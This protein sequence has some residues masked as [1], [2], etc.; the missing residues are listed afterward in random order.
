[1]AAS[2]EDTSNS[3]SMPQTSLVQQ[4]SGENANEKEQ[5]LSGISVPCAQNSDA[6]ELPESLVRKNEVRALEIK[7][8]ICNYGEAIKYFEEI[9]NRVEIQDLKRILEEKITFI[10]KAS[11]I[12]ELVSLLFPDDSECV[13]NIHELAGLEHSLSVEINKMI[14]L[15]LKMSLISA[16][17]KMADAVLHQCI[18]KSLMINSKDEESKEAKIINNRFDNSILEVY[19]QSDLYL[20]Q[21]IQM[22]RFKEL[23]LNDDY[24]LCLESDLNGDR[25][26]AERGKIYRSIEKHTYLVRSSELEEKIFEGKFSSDTN[27]HDL[28]SV[29]SYISRQNHLP[30]NIKEI[31]ISVAHTFYL[32]CDIQFKGINLVIF[33]ADI[34]VTQDI[35]IDLSGKDGINT[36]FRKKALSGTE[37]RVAND[38]TASLKAVSGT[39]GASG[40]PGAWGES[41]GNLYLKGKIQDHP[42]KVKLILNGGRG[43]EGQEGGDGEP[44]A[45]GKPGVAGKEEDKTSMF[46]LRKWAYVNKAILPKE[47]GRGGDCGLGGLGGEGGYA[48]TAYINDKVFVSDDPEKPC[49]GAPGKKSK[50]GEVGAGGRGGNHASDYGRNYYGFLINTYTEEEF[51][52]RLKCEE[53]GSWYGNKSRRVHVIVAP[54][55]LGKAKNG[56]SGRVPKAIKQEKSFSIQRNNFKSVSVENRMFNS[57]SS[58]DE[59]SYDSHYLL[60]DG[61]RERVK[62]IIEQAK[63]EI[64]AQLIFHEQKIVHTVQQFDDPKHN[65]IPK[66][67]VFL[68]DLLLRQNP[69]RILKIEN[70]EKHALIE[71]AAQKYEN[72]ELFFK[73]GLENIY[74]DII[75]D[76]NKNI[77]PE[78]FLKILKYDMALAMLIYNNEQYLKILNVILSEY[79]GLTIPEKLYNF[80]KSLSS[81]KLK[82]LYKFI[83]EAYYLKNSE[84]ED[85]FRKII[86]LIESQITHSIIVELCAILKAYDVKD[87]ELILHNVNQ[88]IV[89]LHKV[90]EKE[91]LPNLNINNYEEIAK[92]KIFIS[93]SVLNFL[94][95]PLPQKD[96]REKIRLIREKIILINRHNSVFFFKICYLLLNKKQNSLEETE[97][98]FGFMDA[99]LKIRPLHS[100]KYKSEAIEDI[101]F[102]N[103]V[104][105]KYQEILKIVL[106][107]VSELELKQDG[108]L[109]FLRII[110]LMISKKLLKK[111]DFFYIYERIKFV[112]NKL[113]H[114][115]DQYSYAKVTKLDMLEEEIIVEVDINKLGEYFLSR[116]E[117]L[118]EGGNKKLIDFMKTPDAHNLLPLLDFI[119]DEITSEY[120]GFYADFLDDLVRLI[121]IRVKSTSLYSNIVEIIEIENKINLCIERCGCKMHFRIIERFIELRRHIQHCL[122]EA[123]QEIYF[124]GFSIIKE[125]Y[126]LPYLDMEMAIDEKESFRIIKSSMEKANIEE[127]ICIE[128]YLERYMED[129]I[130]IDLINELLVDLLKENCGFITTRL[131]KKILFFYEAAILE[132]IIYPNV[133]EGLAIKLNALHE[134]T[135]FL[136]G[137]K[138][139]EAI[140][141]LLRCLENL[142]YEGESQDEIERE[143]SEL[144]FDFSDNILPSMSLPK[145][146]RTFLLKAIIENSY[147]FNILEMECLYRAIYFDIPIEVLKIIETSLEPSSS[148]NNR[149]IILLSKHF[150]GGKIGEA[151]ETLGCLSY[152]LNSYEKNLVDS[153]KDEP[154]FLEIKNTIPIQFSRRSVIEWGYFLES[155]IVDYFYNEFSKKLKGDMQSLQTA[156]VNLYDTYKLRGDF[157]SFISLLKLINQK[158]IFD[159][160][161]SCSNLQVIFE[162]LN[163][164]DLDFEI[165]KKEIYD[166][167]SC[168]WIVNILYQQLLS[169]VLKFFEYSPQA[170]SDLKKYS[171]KLIKEM[172]SK[173]KLN[174]GIMF[175]LNEKLIQENKLIHRESKLPVADLIHILEFIGANPVSDADIRDLKDTPLNQW[176]INLQRGFKEPI[177]IKVEQKPDRKLLLDALIS[178]LGLKIDVFLQ[179]EK[180]SKEEYLVSLKKRIMKV[181]DYEN[182]ICNGFGIAKP[183]KQCDEL[184]FQSFQ[185]KIKQYRE[186]NDIEFIYKHI[187]FIIAL[188]V[189][190]VQISKFVRG[191]KPRESQL[192]ALYLYLDAARHKQG[193]LGEIATGEGKTLIIAMFSIIQ[194]L[195]GYK[196]NIVTSSPVL[197][198]EHAEFTRNLYGLFGLTVDN[199][200][201]TQAVENI[202]QRKIRYARPIVYGDLGSF[203]RD[204][205][206]TDCFKE[207]IL[208]GRNEEN[209]ILVV[210]EVDSLILDKGDNTLY[211]GHDIPDFRHLLPI[212][213]HIWAAAQNPN[214]GEEGWNKRVVEIIKNKI[215]KQEI[216]IVP[217]LKDF[218]DFRLPIWVDSARQACLV[219]EKRQFI[220][221]EKSSSS[222]EKDVV[223]MDNDTGVEQ[224]ALHWSDGLHQFLQLAANKKF[225]DESLKAIF[226]SNLSYFQNFSGRIFG[227]TGTLGSE[228]DKKLFEQLYQVDF[229]QLPRFKP[230]L[231]KKEKGEVLE[232]SDEWLKA[233]Q[234]DVE[235]KIGEERAVLLIINTIE[236]VDNIAEYLEE[237]GLCGIHRYKRSDEPFDI[238]TEDKP[239]ASGDIIIATNLAGRGKDLLISEKL[240][241]KGGLHVILCYMPPNQR[242]DEQA[243]GRAARKGEKG[244]GKFIIQ[245]SESKDIEVLFRNR[246]K[247]VIQKSENFRVTMLQSLVIERKLFEKFTILFDEIRQRLKHHDVLAFLQNI[248]DYF[249][250]QFQSWNSIE[251]F[252]EGYIEI[253]LKSLKDAWSFWLDS[254]REDIQAISRENESALI[255]K[256]DAFSKIMLKEANSENIYRLVKSPHEL[257][258]LGMFFESKRRWCA[259]LDCYNKVIS[260]CPQH[261]EIAQLRRIYAIEKT[262]EFNLEMK[263]VEI[264]KSLNRAFILMQ[265]RMNELVGVR[266][267]HEAINVVRRRAGHV[268]E[269]N[270][271][272]GQISNFIRL[273]GMHC[274]GI[275]NIL[276]TSLASFKSTL[277]SEDETREFQEV[278]FEQHFVRRY[279]LSKKL[280]I[281]EN[282]GTLSVYLDNS[283][284]CERVIFPVYLSLFE[285]KVALCIKEHR[286]NFQS[287]EKECIIEEKVFD[288][289]AQINKIHLWNLLLKHNLLIEKTHKSF[290][291]LGGD[292]FNEDDGLEFSFNDPDVE[293]QVIALLIANEHKFFDDIKFPLKKEEI[294]H[295]KDMLLER[296]LLTEIQS[297]TIRVLY[298]SMRKKLFLPEE[299]KIYH[300]VII[301]VLNIDESQTIEYEIE[302]ELNIS[303][304]DIYL[305]ADKE[306]GMRLIWEFMLSSKIIKPP[307]ID[308]SL[309]SLSEENLKQQL[310]ALEKFSYE[311]FKELM[312]KRLEKY[313]F[314]PMS[315]LLEYYKFCLILELPEQNIQ[316]AE[317]GKIYISKDE[318]NFDCIFLGLDGTPRKIELPPALDR[319]RELTN[320]ELKKEILIIVLKDQGVQLRNKGRP[321]KGKIYFDIET[322]RLGRRIS[323]LFLEPNDIKVKGI[324]EK[325]II[326]DS[327]KDKIEDVK[328]LM[329]GKKSNRLDIDCL[330]NIDA[331]KEKREEVL[332]KILEKTYMNSSEKKKEQIYTLLKDSIGQLRLII[333]IEA[334]LIDIAECL[335]NETY[336]PDVQPFREV[337]LSDI[338]I[339][340]EFISRWNWGAFAVAMFGLVQIAGGLTLDILTLGALSPLATALIAEGVGDIFFAA[341]M[342]LTKQFS[343]KAYAGYKLL[344]LTLSAISIMTM[345]LGAGF[346]VSTSFLEIAAMRG[347]KQSAMAVMK[348]SV[349][350]VGMTAVRMGVTKAIGSGIEQVTSN[351]PREIKLHFG[352]E[353]NRKIRESKA[354]NL[355]M[356]AMRCEIRALRNKVGEEEAHR[357][358]GAIRKEVLH[359]DVSQKQSINQLI[360]VAGSLAREVPNAILSYSGNPDVVIIS[361]LIGLIV[362]GTNMSVQIGLL[363][364]S[365]VSVLNE[366]ENKIKEAA[367][368][369]KSQSDIQNTEEEVG[370]FISQELDE[371]KNILIDFTLNRISSELLEPVLNQ[372]YCYTTKCIF[373]P[374]KTHGVEVISD[375][376]D[377][378]GAPI[379]IVTSNSGSERPSQSETVVVVTHNGD[380][381]FSQ[382]GPSDPSNTGV[383]GSNPNYHRHPSQGSAG[384]NVYYNTNTVGPRTLDY[385]RS[386]SAHVH[387]HGYSEKGDS[388]EVLMPDQDRSKMLM[389]HGIRQPHGVAREYRVHREIDTQNRKIMNLGRQLSLECGR[390]FLSCV[391]VQA[392]SIFSAE[393][394]RS[395][396]KRYEEEMKLFSK[397]FGILHERNIRVM[398]NVLEAQKEMVILYI[399]F[400]IVQ[401]RISLAF[402]DFRDKVEKE[403]EIH[404]LE[405]TV[406]EIKERAR[407]LANEMFQAASRKQQMELIK[408]YID[409]ISGD[410]TEVAD[411][412]MDL[413]RTLANIDRIKQ[414]KEMEMSA[415]NIGGEIAKKIVENID[416]GAM[417]SGILDFYKDSKLAPEERLL[418]D[419]KL[420]EHGYIAMKTFDGLLSAYNTSAKMDMVREK[421]QFELGRGLEALVG[422]AMEN[423]KLG[424]QTQLELQRA[425][426]KM[427]E[428][429]FD[430]LFCEMAKLKE[431]RE[432]KSAAFEARRIK[433]TEKRDKF[434]SECDAMSDRKYDSTKKIIDEETK[435]LSTDI[436]KFWKS[437]ESDRTWHTEMTKFANESQKQLT[438][439]TSDQVENLKELQ[440]MLVTSTEQLTTSY[441]KY[442]ETVA[443][444]RASVFRE[445]LT[446]TREIMSSVRAAPVAPNAVEFISSAAGLPAPASSAPISA[447]SSSSS[448]SLPVL[449]SNPGA[450][451]AA[452]KKAPPARKKKGEEM[453]VLEDFYPEQEGAEG[454][455]LIV[456]E[457][458]IVIKLSDQQGA[459]EG[460]TLCELDGKKGFVPSDYLGKQAQTPKLV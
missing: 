292:P 372:A 220:I 8:Q 207:N 105:G 444:E 125:K 129:M 409:K 51:R 58:I 416:P 316:K 250:P 266:S 284:A 398:E 72:P 244:S 341:Y 335:S 324:I 19:S 148:S 381:G 271:F 359:A 5:V 278:L 166:N 242:I 200:C 362:L 310:K 219:R 370:E 299:L 33:A 273:Y 371:I 168:N 349:K 116:Y 115:C 419:G 342:G 229:F 53:S 26:N 152:L 453:K 201:D 261:C 180:M 354:I 421:F 136:P 79:F 269:S 231:F 145:S 400:I 350:R 303:A 317:K 64:E 272:E 238:G 428:K 430:R 369:K 156:Y 390:I 315:V 87:I 414:Q 194:C 296:S 172:L 237:Q 321:E 422:K 16:L 233:I 353:I 407:A 158:F 290:I 449:S 360:N 154:N 162:L 403:G 11:C 210:D 90:L 107:M 347:A 205:L 217:Y 82:D 29:L 209:T 450:F 192:I 396:K 325:T 21:L 240:E 456:K 160:P 309:K 287:F 97:D 429:S 197:A 126:N 84:C 415:D 406:S 357:I 54:E 327:V 130:N 40:L 440:E 455:E 62:Q 92:L 304:F 211:L 22:H 182:F 95:A 260:D 94:K 408:E 301:A 6:M 241:S 389:Y 222:H 198:I 298:D 164:V 434:V 193:R 373:K 236:D 367:E 41:S 178:E 149:I 123:N 63:A 76:M 239:L 404:L 392:H 288:K 437:D 89:F 460:W 103:K 139:L 306:T 106:S 206:L 334:K 159:K 417:A 42:F 248:K 32:D 264:K 439:L 131:T 184:D 46:E 247:E 144:L 35:E 376:V 137:R 214:S 375:I 302:Q 101:T 427:F 128:L 405:V 442:I 13:S 336:P 293:Q 267:V 397:E 175:L 448:S 394:K 78:S 435:E 134:L 203:Q 343:W 67:E 379:V 2:S 307:R 399:S 80:R 340:E 285:Q 49:S 38:K 227:S 127:S 391:L 45:N 447:S 432:N 188:V 179:E 323:Y 75:R 345:G 374:K 124:K 121:N 167:L 34:Q 352:E 443:K 245:S 173:I 208:N 426:K 243:F 56:D 174:V 358:L 305:P 47:G 185:L 445:F 326:V 228:A 268:Q 48:G 18:K 85:F 457:G 189:R 377:V 423:V 280:K 140:Y 333:E 65:L 52:G 348:F 320:E 181:R 202:E 96:K 102:L 337:L 226:I 176:A 4:A 27:I 363:I 252:W 412:R 68:L 37:V 282:A 433:L 297:G 204:K 277:L 98:L 263:R 195:L 114:N 386:S 81:S 30:Q 218:V 420:S 70:I 119:R 387:Y 190:A 100:S 446:T 424:I 338:L 77:E 213:I 346:A 133:K 93:K 109:K 328:D 83:D 339:L 138:I 61:V 295:V 312:Q 23:F 24:E 155:A 7:F 110:S 319:K 246:D 191:E 235:K 9:I 314:E 270:E 59:G 254:V 364:N 258:R 413:K 71:V 196:V 351:F 418:R 221:A 223:V 255:Q 425:V 454:N 28:Q 147:K 118:I 251:T 294:K 15:D 50:D 36:F 60:L 441:Q 385:K 57:E 380:D 146:A 99:P 31:K 401:Q 276:G 199:N 274:H 452:P 332:D 281:F 55:N 169:T 329:H 225:A 322:D 257:V 88:E 151:D 230:Y 459:S 161:N 365:I 120:D 14:F 111:E 108:D 313:T 170:K 330:E 171:F 361:N 69:L 216:K 12:K 383:V 368:A 382:Q 411:L 275:E 436:E 163:K 10:I 318:K 143:V 378:E 187:D 283:G 186:K 286:D 289:I 44:G 183:I 212:Y 384:P 234:R 17:E 25:K 74:I 331:L 20:S 135:N 153:M 249:E 157:L 393:L 3:L 215:E 112:K 395:I 141:Q 132:E 142:F 308:L 117:F 265:E 113:K 388:A 122:T 438:E 262:E 410:H 291:N 366:I 402:K 300:D 356:D 150:I 165:I 43:A 104:G 355:K 458:D 86:D 224:Y 91:I 39:S 66:N 73:Y 344:S 279:R 232:S 177:P 259:A 1:M 311:K 253:Q 451:L 256:F 431:A